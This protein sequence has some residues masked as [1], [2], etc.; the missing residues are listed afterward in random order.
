[1]KTFKIVY[2]E[3]LGFTGREKEYKTLAELIEKEGKD[4][5]CNGFVS[6]YQV[7]GDKLTKVFN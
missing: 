2:N 5:L 6:I 1:M 3:G 4:R 7:K